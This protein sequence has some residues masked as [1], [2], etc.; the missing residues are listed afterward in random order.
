MATAHL[1]DGDAEAVLRD[2][3]TRHGIRRLALFGSVLTWGGDSGQRRRPAGGVRGGSDARFARPRGAGVGAVWGR[4]VEL[5]TY[6]DLS[7][8]F[9]DDVRARARVLYAA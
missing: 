1:D 3:V 5:R 9:R 8:Y 7:R 6:E 2:F 4:E